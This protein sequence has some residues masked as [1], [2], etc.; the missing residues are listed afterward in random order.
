VAAVDGDDV[1][2]VDGRRHD[3][4]VGGDERVAERV[5]DARGTVRR[6]LCLACGFSS[7]R[8]TSMPTW[9]LAY[10]TTGRDVR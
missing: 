6:C 5:V 3:V 9:G 2:V 4:T 7:D 10:R 1:P 8:S